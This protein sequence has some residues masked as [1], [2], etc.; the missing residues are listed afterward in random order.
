MNL[1][2]PNVSKKVLLT[3]VVVGILGILAGSAGTYLALQDNLSKDDANT[4]NTQT[5]SDNAPSSSM[6]LETKIPEGTISPTEIMKKPTE[7]KD[8]E[9]NVRGILVDGGNKTYF[10]SGQETTGAGSVSLDLSNAA[11]LD[12]NK[13]VGTY[14]DPK[15]APVQEG[16]NSPAIARPVTVKGTVKIDD[17]GKLALFVTSIEE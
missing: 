10:V 2:K 9:V 12:I 14:A 1:A 7:Y 17:S 4:A 13:Y 16:T 5:S 8:K 11:N 6:K 15:Q 3:I